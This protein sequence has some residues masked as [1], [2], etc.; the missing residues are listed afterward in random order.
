MQKVVSTNESQ[1]DSAAPLK[2]AGHHL[3]SSHLSGR[4]LQADTL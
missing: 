3:S 2:Y 1:V 4:H